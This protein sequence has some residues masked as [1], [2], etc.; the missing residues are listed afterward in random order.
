MKQLLKH[1]LMLFLIFYFCSSF[2]SPCF[3]QRMD[4]LLNVYNTQ[5]IRTSGNSFV[6]G[7]QAYSFRDLKNEFT[8]PFTMQL[9]KTARKDKRIGGLLTVG[10]IAGLVGSIIIR[11]NN[12]GLA[13]ALS[14]VAVA[15]NFG[16]IRFNKRSSEVLDQA[17]WQRNKEILFNT[18]E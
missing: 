15:L 16:A 13:G 6:K 3:S 9:Y 8:S 10:A 12:T 11:K 5:T 4:S 18:K 1:P 17:I 7:S 2:V 14:G